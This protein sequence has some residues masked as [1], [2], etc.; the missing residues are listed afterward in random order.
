MYVVVCWL[1]M[2]VI[3]VMTPALHLPDWVDSFLAVFFIAG[4]PISMLIAWAFEITPDGIART[5]TVPIEQSIRETTGRRMDYMLFAGLLFV[6]GLIIYDRM[7]PETQD[8]RNLPP[9]RTAE[10]NS[11]APVEM[12]TIAVL[13]FADIS[14]KQDQKYFSDGVAEE[15]LNLLVKLD[16][17]QVISRSLSFSFKSEG[18]ALNDISRQ[19]NVS[20]FIDGS[21]RREGD[22]VRISVSLIDAQTGVQSWGET[23]NGTLASIFD[24]QEEISRSIVAELKLALDITAQSQ[25]AES[26]TRN[27]RSYDLFLQGRDLYRTSFTEAD[28]MTSL[29]LMEE[30]VELDPQFAEAWAVLGQAYLSA[31]SLAGNLNGQE[32][33][34][35]AK[36]VSDRAISLDPGLSDPYATLGSI[37]SIRG[38][39]VAAIRL[40]EIGRGLD[41][42]NSIMLA[43][44]GLNY[45]ITGRADM[46]ESVLEEAARLDPNRAAFIS[47]VALVKRNLGK[48][49]ESD[50]YAMK[51]AEMGYFIAYDTLAW[52]AY[53]R[54]DQEKAQEYF[55]KIQELG[56]GQLAPDFRARSLWEAAARAYF[57]DSE[58]DKLAIQNIIKIYLDSDNAQING[59]IV[60]LL[61]RMGMHDHFFQYVDEALASRAVA[62]AGMWDDSNASQQ[63][64]QNAKFPDFVRNIGYVDFW[65][66]FGW[67]EECQLN[68][69]GSGNF[70]CN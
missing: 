18:T 6:G 64:R 7:V 28:I 68:A 34:D 26:I 15:I 57:E 39:Q 67:P 53:S 3:A 17:L 14:Q 51:A 40:L 38:D 69:D 12:P 56:G 30:A 46:A 21:V 42:G 10:L 27:A 19:Y 35:K 5:E 9:S 29:G 43:N 52:N 50:V 44:L 36:T 13:P 37:Q 49:D 58:Q 65:N 59:V 70:T 31:P 33:F 47:Y 8:L 54:G 23:Y 61:F 55:L 63:I 62:L 2:Q 1:S 48:Y 66:E 22:N 4:F 25:L 41:P 20:H 60:T 16:N 24:L 45:T 32:Y 11:E